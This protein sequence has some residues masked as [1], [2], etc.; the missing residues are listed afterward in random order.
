[1][2]YPELRG[3]IRSRYKEQADFARA[4]NL[5][6]SSVSHKLNGKTQWSAADIRAACAVLEIPIEDI[7]VYFFCSDC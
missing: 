4:I 7:P 6:P 1:M 5:S 3:K 2:L